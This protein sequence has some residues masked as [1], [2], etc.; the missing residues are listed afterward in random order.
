MICAAT[1][2][3]PSDVVDI[4]NGITGK[5][6]TAVLSVA[7][8]ELAATSLPNQGLAIFGGGQSTYVLRVVGCFA[9][10]VCKS[11]ALRRW[12][13]HLLRCGYLQRDHRHL[14]HRSSQRRSTVFGSHIDA[15]SRTCDLR[16]WLWYESLFSCVVGYFVCDSYACATGVCHAV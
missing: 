16:W 2:S 3:A 10:F 6:S 4:F 11:H 13:R 8:R 7:R 9:E 14:E 5:W 12:Q 1:S 15:E